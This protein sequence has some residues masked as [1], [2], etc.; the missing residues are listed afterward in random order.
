MTASNM[1]A[2]RRDDA[3]AAFFDAAADGVL[4]L[5]RCE[6]GHWNA[7][8][9]M[10]CSTCGSRNLEWAPAS[11]DGAIVSYAVVHRRGADTLPVAIVELAEGPWLRGQLQDIAPDELVEGLVV[12]VRFATPEGGEPIPYF[13]P[14]AGKE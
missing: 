4:V 7:P 6:S 9:A 8:P 2:L 1:F 3:S 12:Q 5:R 11:G 14:T 10:T 13:V